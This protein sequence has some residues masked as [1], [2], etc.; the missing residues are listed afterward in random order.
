MRLERAPERRY[1]VDDGNWRR[2]DDRAIDEAIGLKP[3]KTLSQ[4]LLGDALVCSS[5][6]IEPHGTAAETTKDK[7]RPLGRNFFEHDAI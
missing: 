5:Q 2:A 1:F 7:Q 6:R 4:R 3:A